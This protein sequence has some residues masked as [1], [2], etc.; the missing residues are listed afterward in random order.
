MITEDKINDLIDEAITNL[1]D[2]NVNVGAESLVELAQIF[3]KA[4]MT[5]ESFMNIRKYIINEA[6]ERTDA[7]FIK[8]KLK[9][10]EKQLQEN[11]CGTV[12]RIITH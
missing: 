5:K 3:A 7:V 11:R 4:G 10:A 6:I 8:E 1:A 2:D 9:S 12:K